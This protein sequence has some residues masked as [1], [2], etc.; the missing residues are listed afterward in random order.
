MNRN[1]CIY[2]YLLLDDLL[3]TTFMFRCFR[4]FP[5]DFA[6]WRRCFCYPLP[7]T[8]YSLPIRL[9]VY[10]R[11]QPVIGQHHPVGQGALHG[12]MQPYLVAHV[13]EEGLFRSYPAGQCLFRKAFSTKTSKPPNCSIARSS[14]VFASVR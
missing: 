4:M 14:T 3:F 2:K 13:D 1:F 12:V 10:L 8:R 9:P 6:D 11:F 5:A 7:A